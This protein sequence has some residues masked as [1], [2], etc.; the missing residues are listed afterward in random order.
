VLDGHPVDVGRLKATPSPSALFT[1]T[2]A[3]F[4]AARLEEIGR[5]YVSRPV[6]RK[7]LR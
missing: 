1:G 6:M 2:K 4:D 3:M 7:T 5:T